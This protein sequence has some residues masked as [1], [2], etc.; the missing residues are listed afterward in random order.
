MA[1]RLPSKPRKSR[2]TGRRTSKQIVGQRAEDLAADFLSEH[3]LTVVL[4]NFRRR[5]GEIDLVAREGNTLIIVE[6]RMRSTGRFGGAAAS[7]DFRKQQKLI[8]AAAQLLQRYK[9]FSRLRVRFD[10]IVV[11]Q[12]EAQTPQIDW[13][14]HAFLT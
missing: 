3:G 10:V 6:V 13:L 14:K 2:A 11:S 12:I 7:V 8:R 9:E 4:R 5:L 1:G